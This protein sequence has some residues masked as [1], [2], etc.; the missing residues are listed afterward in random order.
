MFRVH[1]SLSGAAE[2]RTHYY[3][4]MD[5]VDDKFYFYNV[6]EEHGYR[7]LSLTYTFEASFNGTTYRFIDGME[8]FSHT[9]LLDPVIAPGTR[10]LFKPIA[11]TEFKATGG[12][13]GKEHGCEQPTWPVRGGMAATTIKRIDEASS[14]S[15]SS[16]SSSHAVVR[17]EGSGERSRLHEVEE[18]LEAISRFYDNGLITLEDFEAKKQ[19]LLSRV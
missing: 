12:W 16:S 1:R 17:A 4:Q 5:G 8:T 10:V 7:S 13:L 6:K 2:A 15:S 18:S 3:V 9:P 14:S 11:A 19:E